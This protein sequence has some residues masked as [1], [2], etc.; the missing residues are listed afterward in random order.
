MSD[1]KS[2]STDTTTSLE[3]S[4][5]ERLSITY[6]P[7]SLDDAIREVASD[8]AGAISTF[9]G[10]TR[11]NFGGRKVIRLEYE[12]YVQMALSEMKK[13]VS[14]IKSKW[15][16]IGI[17]IQHRLGVVPVGEA[18][19][20][21]VISSAHRRESLDAVSFAIDKVKERVTIWKKE[22]YEGEDPNSAIPTTQP[23]PVWKENKEFIDNVVNNHRHHHAEDKDGGSS[24]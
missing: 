7:L 4:P 14:E 6:K 9:L 13:I 21:I 11:N 22:F 19:V 2:T 24:T 23:Q 3:L 17:N 1:E 16:V 5:K 10:V 20:L 18:S 15:S 8:E 12:G